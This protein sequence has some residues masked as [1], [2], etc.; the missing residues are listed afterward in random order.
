[1]ADAANTKPEEA[2]PEEATPDDAQPDDAQ[3]DKAQPEDASR[4]RLQS[5]DLDAELD[6]LEGTDTAGPG[7]NGEPG[8][9]EGKD[10]GGE[11]GDDDGEEDAG[12]YKAGRRKREREFKKKARAEKKRAKKE[13]K[14]AKKDAKKEEKERLRAENE[15][16]LDEERQQ[17][18]QEEERSLMA[19][20]ELIS[21]EA[22]YRHR[23]YLTMVT[24]FNQKIAADKA[25]KVE[26]DRRKE[27][28]REE[29]FY[30]DHGSLQT[31]QTPKDKSFTRFKTT[32]SIVT[33][34]VGHEGAVYKVRFS[35][36]Q[37]QMLTCSEDKTLKLWDVAT[38]NLVLTLGADGDGHTKVVRDCDL[39]PSY[40]PGER[41]VG[42]RIAMSCSMDM[43]IRFWC[44]DT[45]LEVHSL[46]GH[47]D[48]IT[49]CSFSKAGD[50]ALTCSMDGTFRMWLTSLTKPIMSSK[51]AQVFVYKGHTGFLSN[52][53]FSPSE[54][55]IISWGGYGDS[56]IRLWNAYSDVDAGTATA[57]ILR[58]PAVGDA[59]PTSGAVSGEGGFISAMVFEEAKEGFVFKTGNQ[60]I[61][62]YP[63][64]PVKADA[65]MMAIYYPPTGGEAVP[66]PLLK[67]LKKS[68]LIKV[69]KKR[70]VSILKDVKKMDAHNLKL[71]KEHNKKMAKLAK[72]RVKEIREKKK[73]DAKNEKKAFQ[74]AL[75]GDKKAPKKKGKL[76]TA[77]SVLQD[78]DNMQR[79]QMSEFSLSTKAA[80][81]YLEFKTVA[82]KRPLFLQRLVKAKQV[83]KYYEEAN[84]FD[85]ATSR[86]R[87]PSHSEL[88]ALKLEQRRTVRRG[89]FSML[90]GFGPRKRIRILKGMHDSDNTVDADGLIRIMNHFPPKDEAGNTQPHDVFSALGDV[91]HKA[92]INDCKFSPCERRLASCA[93]DGSIKVSQL[94]CFCT[95]SFY[96]AES[97]L[98][99]TFFCL[100]VVVNVAHLSFSCG[101]P[102]TGRLFAIWTGMTGS[103]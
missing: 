83:S 79:A 34:F 5:D 42:I 49:A 31:K 78:W 13:A 24:E 84:E 22:E 16:M 101:I 103:L 9:E 33:N 71:K 76:V 30:F 95:S 18:E 45:K 36:D 25:K 60:G 75:P 74:M 91:G 39:H 100:S 90:P 1:M 17:K 53:A 56:T 3:P 55:C 68:N 26:L 64:K 6:A 37:R 88:P 19:I 38:G 41:R 28:A 65:H 47:A 11:G 67:Q 85:L 20:E 81:E 40:V 73:R 87:K 46:V 98:A 57:E 32:P 61:G 23:L 86:E 10:A 44:L 48:A 72:Q 59:A 99:L 12:D 93:S 4:S 82:D 102:Q 89:G 94:S 97:E 27:M 80:T 8:G 92:W 7:E 96:F 35:S 52:C 70:A 66:E 54:N 14:Q 50:L 21:W 58:L 29:G 63:D 62:Y 15:R 51:I 69:D 2:K 77:E 43:T